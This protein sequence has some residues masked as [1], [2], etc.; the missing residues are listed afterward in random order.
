[1]AWFWGAERYK[2]RAKGCFS[3]YQL[4]VKGLLFAESIVQPGFSARRSVRTWL[5]TLNKGA[6]KNIPLVND[7]LVVLDL[8][9]QVA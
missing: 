5:L 1:M 2:T 3:F 6:A 8:G 4:E 9:R 7:A